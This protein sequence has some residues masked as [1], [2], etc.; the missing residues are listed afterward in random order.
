MDDYKEC[1][2]VL[3]F[4]DGEGQHECWKP[5]DHDGPHKCVSCGEE[6]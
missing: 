5:K 4:E 2:S 6:W 1:E 3:P